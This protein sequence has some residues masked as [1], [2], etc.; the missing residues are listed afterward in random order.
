[1]KRGTGL[2][3]LR[4]LAD[5]C[6][7]MA[8]GPAAGFALPVSEFWVFGAFLDEPDAVQEEVDVALVVD[9]PPD[10]AHWLADPPGAEHWAN[11][12]RLARSPLR[13]R[14][15]PQ[16][17]PV[18]NHEIRRPLLL[19]DAQD[20]VREAAFE[21]LGSSAYEPLRLAEPTPGELRE[22]LVEEQAFCLAALRKATETYTDK[23]WSPGKLP[24]IADPLHL[25]ALGYL[26]V[27]DALT[28]LD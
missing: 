15:R 5:Q 10:V 12:T 20:G 17:F 23:R 2:H 19:W 28:H 18:W 6:Q 21:A 11:M 7:A 9:L 16:G 14:W 13:P 25:A 22:R 24:K 26:D 8:T 1:M 3:R 27:L 4:E